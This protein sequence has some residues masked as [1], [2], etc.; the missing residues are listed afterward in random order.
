MTAQKQAPRARFRAIDGEA[1]GD[2]IHNRSNRARYPVL[3]QVRF[4]DNAALA[5]L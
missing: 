4:G 5:S 1:F 3:S 2:Q